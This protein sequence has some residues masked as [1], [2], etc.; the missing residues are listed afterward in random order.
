MWVKPISL[1]I[2]IVGVVFLIVSWNYWKNHA[3]TRRIARARNAPAAND[4]LLRWPD[5]RALP[6]GDLNG[7]VTILVTA[8]VTG[9]DPA[10]LSELVTFAR[11]LSPGGV[12][13]MVQ[14]VGEGD[15]QGDLPEGV[16]VLAVARRHPL[17]HRVARDFGPV[18]AAST[19]LV[20]DGWGRVRA[21][22][23]PDTRP[24]D[25][26]LYR[27]VEGAMEDAEQA[28]EGVG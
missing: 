19:K 4:V 24:P 16:E 11:E 27:A 14:P 9:I 8:P 6:V 15:F 17:A 18:D 7:R 26:E 12:R 2:V 20:I 10:E 22:L 3:R 25:A 5:G 21:L 28:A 1:T 13:I 23:T